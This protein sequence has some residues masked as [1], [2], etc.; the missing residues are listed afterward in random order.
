MLWLMTK[1]PKVKSLGERNLDE[2]TGVNWLYPKPEG[3]YC[4]PGDFFIDPHS[5]VERAV[6]THGHSDH[7]CAGHKNVLATPETLAVTSLR[8]GSGSGDKKQPQK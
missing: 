7:A 4:E 2:I 5:A 6:V 8:L 1:R 3:L